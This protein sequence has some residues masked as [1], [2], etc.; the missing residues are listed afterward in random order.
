MKIRKIYNYKNI[1]YKLNFFLDFVYYFI[2]FIQF[3]LSQF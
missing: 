2:F 3:Y 1:K